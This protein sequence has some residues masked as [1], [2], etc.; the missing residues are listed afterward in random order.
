LEAARV[1]RNLS[2]QTHLASYKL[3]GCYEEKGGPK[4]LSGPPTLDSDA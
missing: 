1:Q 2:I 4:S 3:S